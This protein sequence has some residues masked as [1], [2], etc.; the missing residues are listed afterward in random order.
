M[1]LFNSTPP[2]VPPDG[3]RLL[4]L[5]ALDLTGVSDARSILTQPRRVALLAMLVL[6]GARGFVRRDRLAAIFWPEQDTANA[7]AAL[8]KAVHALRRA[9]GDESVLARGD[10]ELRV[11]PDRLWCD[12]LAFDAAHQAGAHAR[13]LELYRGPLLDGFHAD[14]AEFDRWLDTAREERREAAVGSAWALASRLEQEQD[15]TRA[16]HWARRVAR[17]AGTDERRVRAAMGLLER[18]GSRA[19]AVRI[20]DDFAAFLQREFEVAPATETQAL[21]ARLRGD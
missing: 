6:E 19:D 5:G 3:P 7:R 16:A 9:L 17:L 21:A 12:A 8:R 10:D 15:L 13:A 1:G 2:F 4:L 18:A 14:L 11:D 20:Y